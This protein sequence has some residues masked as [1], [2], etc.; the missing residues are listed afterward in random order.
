METIPIHIRVLESQL[1]IIDAYIKEN[2]LS[3]TTAFR[4]LINEMT[5]RIL[6][7]KQKEKL[8]AASRKVNNQSLKENKALTETLS[9]GLAN[10]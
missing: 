7:A 6:K 5:T 9:D 4:E 2:N 1:D 3:R 8:F 10:E